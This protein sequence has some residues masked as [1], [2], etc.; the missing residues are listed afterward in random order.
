MK[1]LL[2]SAATMLA[3]TT[4]AQ[5]EIVTFEYDFMPIYSTTGNNTA[6]SQ[7]FTL[8]FKVND[9][10]R[11]GV[12]HESMDLTVKNGGASTTGNV[13]I[14]ALNLEFTAL[15][16]EVANVKVPTIIGINLG[17]ANLNTPIVAGA[18]TIA[19]STEMLSDIYVKTLYS[20]GDSAYISA[21]LGYRMLPLADATGS[22]DTTNGLFMK[23]GVGVSF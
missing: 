19:A 15:N 3:L 2:L 5:A 6:S 7:A 21:K 12:M 16:T 18:A 8:A 9:K 4:T 20:A 22:F 13:Q 10:L 23:I 11:A 14:D 17:T 1:K